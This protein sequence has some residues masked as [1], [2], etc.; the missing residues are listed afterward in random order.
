ME[1]VFA[2]AHLTYN[3]MVLAAFSIEYFVT[4]TVLC[5]LL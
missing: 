1:K 4:K 2:G 3:F 5:E